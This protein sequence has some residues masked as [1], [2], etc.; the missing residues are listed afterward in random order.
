AVQRIS[1][2]NEIS[3]REV[4]QA[5]AGITLPTLAANRGYLLGKEPGLVRAAKALSRLMVRYGLLTQED[6][7][8]NLVLPDALPQNGP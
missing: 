7:L 4:R 8:R 3:P 2:R 6:D 1:A 5:L